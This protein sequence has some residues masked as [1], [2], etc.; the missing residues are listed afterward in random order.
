MM[1]PS[2]ITAW[3]PWSPAATHN[4]WGS[5]KT[6]SCPG[7]GRLLVCAAF[8]QGLR[9]RSLVQW[10]PRPRSAAAC[11]SRAHSCPHLPFP[12]S[13]ARHSQHLLRPR[14]GLLPC[15]PAP[16]HGCAPL[17]ASSRVFSTWGGHPPSRAICLC[18]VCLQAL[19]VRPNSFSAGIH[20]P[21]PGRADTS[22]VRP[23]SGFTRG[24]L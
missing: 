24:F 15:F 1:G 3:L 23:M 20:G 9:G 5:L 14:T 4:P 16:R 19:L 6:T 10:L 13:V 18:A 22:L 17:S 11:H 12:L 21:V 8:P 7:H 2:G